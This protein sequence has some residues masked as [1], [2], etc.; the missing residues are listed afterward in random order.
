LQRGM[1][2][3]LEADKGDMEARIKEA[4]G[5]RGEKE[6]GRKKGGQQSC[7]PGRKKKKNLPSPRRG[8]RD[9]LYPFRGAKKRRGWTKD[10]SGIGGVRGKRKSGRSRR[11]CLKCRT[12]KGLKTYQRTGVRTLIIGK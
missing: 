12:K 2:Y 10:K 3:A 9:L 8:K 6:G 4:G 11:K 5:E 7:K 1:H